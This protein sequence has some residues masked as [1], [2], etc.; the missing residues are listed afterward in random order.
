[1]I[2]LGYDPGGGKKDGQG[3]S[4]VACLSVASMELRTS[5]CAS[6]VEALEW[7]KGQCKGSNPHAV[8]ID[9]F[10]HWSAGTKGWR[11][12]D[13]LLQKNY[14]EVERSIQSQNSAAGSMAIQGMALAILARRAWPSLVLNEVHP[15]V[16]YNELW[17]NPYPRS[18]SQ[19]DKEKRISCV[20][21]L[22]YSL[23][24]GDMTCEDEFDAALC[25]YA[26]Q[27]GLNN[28]WPDLLSTLPETSDMIFPQPNVL[29]LWPKLLTSPPS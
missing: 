12:V 11:H 19:G 17:K 10:L 13:R 3:K 18:R 8:G 21:E 24:D 26:T 27:A 4:G 6:V 16:L 14:P 29:Y 22:K 20:R 15:K 25:C 23:L 5:Q 1:M 28:K 9:T 2:I 7:F